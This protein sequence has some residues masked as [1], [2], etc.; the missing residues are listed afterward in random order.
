MRSPECLWR[1]ED[2]W[3]INEIEHWTKH[4]TCMKCTELAKEAAEW[5]VHLSMP[6]VCVCVLA[7]LLI[8]KLNAKIEKCLCESLFYMFYRKSDHFIRNCASFDWFLC[9]TFIAGVFFLP[10]AVRISMCSR[11]MFTFTIPPNQNHHRHHHHHRFPNRHFLLS[12]FVI[13]VSFF[14]SSLFSF[15]SFASHLRMKNEAWQCR[16]CIMPNNYSNNNKE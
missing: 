5:N 10:F 15:A 14:C 9:Q 2:R 7:L 3:N 12:A 11:K 16:P 6:C 8:Q 13:D 4:Y 1:W